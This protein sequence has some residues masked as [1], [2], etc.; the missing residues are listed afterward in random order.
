[1]TVSG[2]FHI[3]LMMNHRPI[4]VPFAISAENRLVSGQI[5][6]ETK[7]SSRGSWSSN[8]VPDYE[9]YDESDEF[10]GYGEGTSSQGRWIWVFARGNCGWHDYPESIMSKMKM[11]SFLYSFPLYGQV[12]A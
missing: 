1:M 2:H 8:P 11:Y 10:N 9:E 12:R 4:I 5:Q 7:K 6:V 3:I